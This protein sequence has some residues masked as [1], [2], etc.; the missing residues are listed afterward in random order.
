MNCKCK[1]VLT[2]LDSNRAVSGVVVM[3]CPPLLNLAIH[4]C[5]YRK[6]A[7]AVFATSQRFKSNYS[8]F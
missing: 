3:V 6:P 4:T 5:R 8:T 1:P 2:T 7:A